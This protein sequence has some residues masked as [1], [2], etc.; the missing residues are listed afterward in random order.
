MLNHEVHG[1]DQYEDPL[2]LLYFQIV[3]LQLLKNAIK[4]SNWQKIWMLKS[5]PLK[6]IIPRN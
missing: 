4:E 3:A 5:Q 6:E 2:T 1:S